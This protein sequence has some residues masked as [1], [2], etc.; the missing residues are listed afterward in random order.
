MKDHFILRMTYSNIESLRRTKKSQPHGETIVSPW[1]WPFYLQKD[2]I[3]QPTK[4]QLQIFSKTPVRETGAKT[5]DSASPKC[6]GTP[7]F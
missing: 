3:K 6:L 1:K 7:K 5:E 4:H 2:R